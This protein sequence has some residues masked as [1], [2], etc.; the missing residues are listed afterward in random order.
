MKE[1]IVLLVGYQSHLAF[2]LLP[3]HTFQDVL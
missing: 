3:Y 2:S 1:I